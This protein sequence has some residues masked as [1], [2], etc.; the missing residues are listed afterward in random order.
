MDEI[1]VQMNVYISYVKLLADPTAKDE[2]KLKVTQE[3]SE[4]LEVNI[5][6]MSI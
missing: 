1:S 6:L 4:E 3:L 5:H 2:N